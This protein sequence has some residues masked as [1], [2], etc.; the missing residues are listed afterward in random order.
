M[1][2]SK[3]ETLMESA[4]EVD[5]VLKDVNLRSFSMPQEKWWAQEAVRNAL[6]LTS[7]RD[8]V[9]QEHFHRCVQHGCSDQHRGYAR[10]YLTYLASVL[11]EMAKE[12]HCEPL[13]ENGKRDTK[14]VSLVTQ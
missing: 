12:V 3:Y 5:G 1:R 14:V 10:A 9:R 11:R 7:I 13:N 2:K 4:R 8:E 6:H